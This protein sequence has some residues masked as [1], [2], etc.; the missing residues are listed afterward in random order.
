MVEGLQRCRV[1]DN[2]GFPAIRQ[3]G[4]SSYQTNVTV[5]IPQGSMCVLGQVRGGAESERFPR[6]WLGWLVSGILNSVLDMLR[7]T[8]V[9]MSSSLLN[10]FVLFMS[11]KM[12]DILGTQ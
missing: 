3:L 9:A 11:K 2:S 5:F 7:N 6:V 8:K 4:A 10:I 12:P 1:E